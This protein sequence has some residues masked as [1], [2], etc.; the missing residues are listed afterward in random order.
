MGRI[1]ET[2]REARESKNISLREAEEATKIRLK[3]LKDLENENFDDL[4]GRAYVIGFLKTYAK[5]LQIEDQALVEE[6]KATNRSEEYVQNQRVKS[7]VNKGLI[8]NQLNRLHSILL[9][10]IAIVLLLGTNFLYNYFGNKNIPDQN[11][12]LV[13]EVV[14]EKPVSNEDDENTSPQDENEEPI[15]QES[16][17][18]D[19]VQVSIK[20]SDKENSKCW[21]N[22]VSDNKTIFS[23]TLTAGEEKSFEANEQLKVKLGNAGV[24]Y[25]VANGE[26]LGVLGAEGAV[27]TKT[28][29][30]SDL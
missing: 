1:G 9:V 21:V 8:N 29:E 6:Y 14:A 20:I 22:I 24:A 4:P 13:P 26:E 7:N 18:R 2:L 15:V 3:Y 28:F 25:I 19:K 5:Y 30:K 27:I 12:T 11:E 16:V 23:G 17:S 10:G